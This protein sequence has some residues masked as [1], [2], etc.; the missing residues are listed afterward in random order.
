MKRKS[1]F[2]KLFDVQLIVVKGLTGMLYMYRMPV[3]SLPGICEQ[4]TGPHPCAS[5]AEYRV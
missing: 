5:V 2:E 4:D 3:I 1:I